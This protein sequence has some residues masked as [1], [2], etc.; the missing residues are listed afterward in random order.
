MAQREAEEEMVVADFIGYHIFI[1]LFNGDIDAWEKY[2]R[3][4]GGV[5][6]LLKDY[7]FVIWLKQ[8]LQEDKDLTNRIKNLVRD[9][10][11]LK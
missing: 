3:D 8:Q 2:L 6:Q 10:T 9:T 11:A 4:N 5:E 1:H 7:P